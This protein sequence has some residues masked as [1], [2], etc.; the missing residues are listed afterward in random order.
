MRLMVCKPKTCRY[1]V[2]P[3]NREQLDRL[4]TFLVFGVIVGGYLEYVFSITRNIISSILMKLF[5]FGTEECCF[6]VAS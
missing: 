2:E 5:A 3:L 6:T 4:L 1:A